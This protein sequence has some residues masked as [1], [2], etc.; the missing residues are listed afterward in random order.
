[1][2]PVFIR[3]SGGSFGWQLGVQSTD[4][5]LVFTTRKG[6]DGITD[7]KL[8]LGADASV[9][10][11][12]VGRQAS[13]ST[14]QNF[15]A[16]VYSYSRARGLFAGVALDGTAIT[17]D[18]RANAKF[19]GKRGVTPSDVFSGAVTTNDNAAQRFLAVVRSSTSAGQTAASA[20]APGSGSPDPEP[21]EERPPAAPA[22]GARTFPLEDPNPGA[23]PR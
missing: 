4:L 11:G 15:T 22:S 3:V 16:E 10:A 12:P 7:G 6:V 18:H 2:N 20:S 8:T 13:A 1:S 17:I 23:E 21:E 9:A 5:V 19:Y 14:D